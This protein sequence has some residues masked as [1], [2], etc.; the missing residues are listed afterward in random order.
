MQPHRHWFLTILFS[1][2]LIAGALAPAFTPAARAQGECGSAPAPRL[3]AGG[4]GMVTFTDGRPL[5]VRN[6]AGLSGTQIGQL[7]EGTTFAVVEGPACADSIYWWHVTA[8]ALTGWI[9]EG[10]EGEYFVAPSAATTLQGEVTPA[11]PVV[12]LS[13]G[14]GPFTVWDWATFAADSWYG[15]QPDPM[16]IAP[17][18]VYSGDLPGLPVDLSGVMFLEDAG[19]NQAQLALLAQNGFVVVPGGL[20]QFHPAYRDSGAWQTW[21][22]G[23]IYDG[24]Q[25]ADLPPG[26][27]FFIT[28]DAT[29][30]AL[31]FIFDNLL[32]D[33]E[34]ASFYPLLTQNVVT[35]ALQAAHAQTQAAAG[36]ALESPARSAELFLAVALELLAPGNAAPIVGAE[37]MSAVT[38]LVEM[39]LAAQGQLD[40]PFLT[41]YQEDFSQYR[42]RGHYDGDPV[43]EQYFRGMMWLSRITFLA[44][45]PQATQIALLLLRALRSSPEA[46]AGWTTLHET[47]TF[48]IGP[49]DD[50]GPT[51][52]S[53][54][55]AAIYHPADLP[56]DALADLERLA[57]FQAM[58]KTLPGPRINGLILPDST[59]AGEMSESG[60]GFRFLGQRFT[61]DGYVM[62]QLMYPY[63]GTRE[64]PRLLPLSLDVAAAVG[65]AEMPYFLAVQAGAGDFLNYDA[66]VL[67][68]ASELGVLGDQDWLE[69]TYGAWLWTL[70][71]L[72]GRDPAGYPPLMQTEA[73]LRKDLQTGLASW[74][75]LKHDTVLYAKQP[76]GLGGGGAPLTSFGYVEPNPLVFARIAVVAALTHQGLTERGLVSLDSTEYAG[77]QATLYQLRGLAYE[78]A[79][80]AEIA[81][82]E[83]AGEPRT[84]DEYWTIFGFGQY[85]WA[86]LITLSTDPDNPDPVALVTDVASNPSAQIVLQEAVGNVD[87]IYVVAPVSTG[88]W[89]LLRGGVFTY[90][91]WVGNINERMTDAEWRAQVAAGDLPPRPAWVSAFYAE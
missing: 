45:D 40:V 30:H 6:A 39:A 59:A 17:P 2:A 91:E 84:E 87:Y 31:H 23:V 71:P 46:I 72:W 54:V 89:Q 10:M 86:M 51:E 78:A 3:V 74:T 26:H 75:E 61:L 20:D 4:A 25:N 80:L 50:L 48:L 79:Q 81:R 53:A 16:Q 21:P 55:T 66:Q 22:E 38:P 62:G 73:W 34:K 42:P 12:P 69:N 82:K 88:G 90:Y 8:G 15:D 37:A 19:L 76:S 7:P 58:L 47:L 28:T 24:S 1:V 9:A 52:Y 44:E 35:P 83:L 70:K 68:L 41:N 36:T 63:V 14:T 85:L 57:A 5:N 60:R 13:Q 43:L 29:L 64:N 65:G 77:F 27:A 33:L 18:D 11:G 49:V 67:K 56:L 32:T